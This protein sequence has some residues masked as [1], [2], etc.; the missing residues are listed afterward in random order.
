MKFG[1]RLIQYLG[2]P[3]RLVDLAGQADHACLEDVW[4]PHDAF[5]GN[6]WALTSAVALFG[7]PLFRPGPGALT[8]WPRSFRPVL[9]CFFFLGVGAMVDPRF[10]GGRKLGNLRKPL[11]NSVPTNHGSP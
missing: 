3:R 11:K 2:N 10:C 7:T 8:N 6:T 5:M 1:L 4:F 9:A